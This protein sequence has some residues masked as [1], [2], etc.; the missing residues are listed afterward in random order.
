MGTPEGKVY[1]ENGTERWERAKPTSL[2]RRHNKFLQQRGL[3]QKPSPWKRVKRKWERPPPQSYKL[4]DPNVYTFQGILKE[5]TYQDAKGDLYACSENRRMF[6]S[7][8]GKDINRGYSKFR[9]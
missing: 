5:G 4:V 2:E 9:N 1:Y 8:I 3:K 6:L 7:P